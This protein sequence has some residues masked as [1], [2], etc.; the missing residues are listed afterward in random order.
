[1][2]DLN[3]RTS[4]AYGV[5]AKKFPLPACGERV[6]VRGAGDWPPA[7]YNVDRPSNAARIVSKT[8]VSRREISLS[9]AEQGTSIP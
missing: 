4:I 2:T 3:C 7:S 9:L 1:M 8:G 6:R 5:D